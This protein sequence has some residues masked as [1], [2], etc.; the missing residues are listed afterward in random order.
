MASVRRLNIKHSSLVLE[1]QYSG[2]TLLLIFPDGTGPALLQCCISGIPLNRVHEFEFNSGE[3]RVNIDYVSAR[4]FLSFEPSEDYLTIIKNGEEELKALREKGD[5]ILNV[6]E[7]QY[8]LEQKLDEEKKLKEEQSIQ[9]Q[10]EKQAT[11][12]RKV[13]D[14]KRASVVIDEQNRSSAIIAGLTAVGGG[15][16]LALFG[17]DSNDEEGNIADE[18]K[19]DSSEKINQPESLNESTVSKPSSLLDINKPIS[20]SAS[21][22]GSNQV[23]NKDNQFSEIEDQDTIE[24]DLVSNKIEEMKTIIPEFVD[25]GSDAWLGALGEIMNEQDETDGESYDWQ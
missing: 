10:R 11:E 17:S 12:K 9:E 25:D 14:E 4:Q 6:R 24:Q 16:A 3:A 2:D 7:Q 5:Q 8:Q 19:D 18:A 22:S 1:T 13:Q 20:L 15:S 21:L 23:L